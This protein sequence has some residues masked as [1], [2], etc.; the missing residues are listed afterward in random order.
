METITQRYKIDGMDF[1]NEIHDQNGVKITWGETNDV[2]TDWLAAA[3]AAYERLH[4][5]DPEIL[6][7]VGGLCWNT[8]LRAMTKKVGPRMAFDNGKLVFTVHVYTFSFWWSAED[9]FVE[10]VATPVSLWLSVIFLS[11]SA[12]GFCVY[13]Q[14]KSTERPSRCG[15]YNVLEENNPCDKCYR[16]TRR[17][18]NP[19]LQN[20]LPN[21]LTVSPVTAA[22][23]ASSIIFHAGWLALAA[24]YFNT[25]TSAGCSSFAADSVWLITLT[26][27]LTLCS[28]LIFI[29]CCLRFT[30]LHLVSF[31]LLWTG[32]LFM[33]I[34][35]VGTYL[36][37]DTAYYDS[38]KTWAL[39]DRPVPV[40]VGEIGT[41]AP[42]EPSFQ[43]LWQYIRDKYDLDFAY[44]AFNGRKFTQQ[45]WETESF[46]LMNDQ[47]SDWR[48]PHWNVFL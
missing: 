3:T 48:F 9:H 31:S 20:E 5:I 45:G 22:F 4:R 18:N 14:R 47:Y 39:N 37:S 19:E 35:A 32:I 41:G 2:D 26:S 30:L 42:N 6:A 15:A 29:C 46:G 23:L 36:S 7:I 34:F 17:R 10:N 12:I 43:L 25:A 13:D 24:F 21:P 8:D 44:W 11:S 28:G 33:S 40:W 16:Y 1:R 27:I 38:L